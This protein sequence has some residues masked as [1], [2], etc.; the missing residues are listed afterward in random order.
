ME[1]DAF[2]DNDVET[3]ETLADQWRWQLKT[4]NS[5]GSSVTNPEAW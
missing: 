3:L 1:P 4:F 5:T 2:D